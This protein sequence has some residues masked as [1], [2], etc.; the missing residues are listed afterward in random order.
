MPIV[1]CLFVTLAGCKPVGSGI[2][3]GYGLT[4]NMIF[5]GLCIKYKRSIYN[6]IINLFINPTKVDKLGN[7]AILDF[8]LDLLEQKPAFTF[9]KARNIREDK[10]VE[11]AQK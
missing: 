11:I 2:S 5:M 8:G 7:Q 3:I 4:K 10:R 9:P 6:R 1:L